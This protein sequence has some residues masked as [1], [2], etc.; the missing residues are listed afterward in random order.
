MC[1]WRF[2]APDIKKAVHWRSADS[3]APQKAKVRDD[4]SDLGSEE[5][6]SLLESEKELLVLH[7]DG[8]SHG[9]PCVQDGKEMWG[10]REDGSGLGDTDEVDWGNGLRV[11]WRSF[12]EGEE[13]EMNIVL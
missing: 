7:P 1:A 2:G 5:A 11:R 9:D 12:R 13:W 10:G 3:E 4:A 6:Q 8:K